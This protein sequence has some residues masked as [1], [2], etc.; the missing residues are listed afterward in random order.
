LIRVTPRFYITYNYCEGCCFPN[1]FLS[2]F[3]ICIKEGYWSV[4]VS[5]IPIDFAEVVCQL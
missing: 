1:F 3:I 5:F 4:W 2:Q